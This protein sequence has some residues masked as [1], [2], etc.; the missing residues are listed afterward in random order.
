MARTK[1]FKSGN[2]S[3]VRFP[4]SFAV[5]PG[6]RV[7]VREDQGRWIVEPV[8]EAPKLIDL[9][10][11]WGSCPGIQ[12]IIDRSFDERPSERIERELQQAM[13]RGGPLTNDG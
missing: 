1:V 7:D 11:I 10:G 13:G 9:T 4:A 6:M 3:A 2:A 5:P 12:P 8:T